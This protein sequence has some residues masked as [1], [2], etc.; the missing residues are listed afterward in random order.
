VSDRVAPALKV[1]RRL[2]P[3]AVAMAV[4]VAARQPHPGEEAT[5]PAS[6]AATLAASAA[7]PWLEPGPVR[8][9]QRVA[10][11]WMLRF[12]PDHGAWLLDVWVP[13]AGGHPSWRLEVAQWLPGARLSSEA[14]SAWLGV[15]PVAAREQLGRRDWSGAGWAL[16]GSLPAGGRLPRSGGAS[17]GELRA[18]LA[19]LLLA[20]ATARRLERR[21]S[22]PV[23]LGLVGVAA[24]GMAGLA[25]AV[26]P[27]GGRLL[28]AEIRPAVAGLAW[29]AGVAML[30]G[31]IL[32]A[33]I[34]CP[35]AR[36]LKPARLL[37]WAFVLGLAAAS[38]APVVWVAELASVA[39]PIPALAVAAVLGG[40]LAGLAGDGLGALAASL[41]PARVPLLIAAA[42][43]AVLVGGPLL[44]PSLAVVAV[45]AGG[46]EGG[47]WLGLAVVAG[48]LVGSLAV[49]CVWPEVQW[50]ACAA[51][52]GGLGATMLAAW[53]AEA[54]RVQSC[55]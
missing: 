54:R 2:G 32:F 21:L 23:W 43:A 46:R 18:V 30:M 16:V 50:G 40:W 27:L 37:P 33:A 22:D 8:G 53:A 41:G 17:S 6:G 12:Q 19:G 24:V 26:F 4:V 20:G 7:S 9:W 34:T 14:A 47:A 44:G 49:V 5:Q 1:L 3:V 52:V 25:P 11:G 39:A 13:E 31:G 48:V 35:T 45:A 15:T 51:L 29:W 55:G 28:A 42:V 10:S 36:G 38:A